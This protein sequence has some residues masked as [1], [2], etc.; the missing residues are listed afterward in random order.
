MKKV[1]Q[2]FLMLC[3]MF[4]ISVPA[5]A[6]DSDLSIT[7][8][9]NDV[10]AFSDPIELPEIISRGKAPQVTAV[11]LYGYGWIDGTD[12]WGVI[13]KVT[14]VGSDTRKAYWN[15]TQL[16]LDDVSLYTYWLG[17]DRTAV[18]FAYLYDCGPITEPGE[19]TFKTTY[20]S[21]NSPY[22]QKS[23][24]VNFTFEEVTSK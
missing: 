20:T 5:F 22:T 17:A 11:E 3:L 19:Y 7:V 9:S 15:D 12:H 14:G 6:A 13:V 24:S 10:I 18:A 8:D 21:V 2:I 4:S 16:G 23:I 1:V